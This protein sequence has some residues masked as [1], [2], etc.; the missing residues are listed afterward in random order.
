[1]STYVI[2]G[3]GKDN[4]QDYKTN[5]MQLNGF[6]DLPKFLQFALKYSGTRYK[7]LAFVLTF[8]GQLG[9]IPVWTQITNSLA[10]GIIL[11]F[12]FT[13]GILVQDMFR[14]VLDRCHRGL[15]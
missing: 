10:V 15:R 12:F 2:S 8:L 6:D 1:M 11:C 13:I 4:R 3:P 9:G 7:K 14:H 5:P